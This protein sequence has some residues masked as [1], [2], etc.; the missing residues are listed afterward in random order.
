MQV[1]EVVFDNLPAGLLAEK[2]W[3]TLVTEGAGGSGAMLEDE[4]TGGSWKRVCVSKKTRVPAGLPLSPG[5]VGWVGPPQ[6]W[7]RLP[8]G[9]D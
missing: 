1:K 3:R 6:R 5:M 4:G 9:F 7:K 8:R 2:S